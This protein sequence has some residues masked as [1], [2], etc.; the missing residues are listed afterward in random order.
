MDAF[1][2]PTGMASA[3]APVPSA[4]IVSSV[5]SPVAHIIDASRPSRDQD[6]LL[7]NPLA[8]ESRVRPLPSGFTTA[9]ASLASPALGCTKATRL[10]S[11][12][13]AGVLASAEIFTG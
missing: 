6:T 10:P 3:A 1:Q 9:S 12:D 5:H 4:F 11:G 2:I 8:G 7:R 13:H